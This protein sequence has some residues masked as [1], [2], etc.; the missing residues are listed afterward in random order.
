VSVGGCTTAVGRVGDAASPSAGGGHAA[1]GASAWAQGERIVFRNTE[2]GDEYGLVASVPLGAPGGPRTLGPV[3]CDRV[4]ATAVAFSCLTAQRGVSTSYL[5]T[6][7]SNDGREMTHWPLAGVPSRTRFS[8]DGTL[9][10]TTSFVTGSAYA[11]VGFSTSTSIR[12]VQGTDLAGKLADW[13]LVLDGK[14]AEPADRNYW[15]ITFIDDTTFYATVGLTAAGRTY[16][17]RG[18]LTART[19]TSVASGVECPSLSPDGRRLAFKKVTDGFGPTV[20]WTPAVLELASGRVTVL[21][22]ETHKLDDQIAWLDDR[23]LLYGL[24]GSAPGDS[25]VWALAADG[26][27]APRLFVRHAWSP[28]VVRP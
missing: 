14:R 7:Y 4:A 25:D 8:P 20:H 3:A 5:A 16:L 10:A 19:M 27:S 17:V 12:T 1:S 24:P 9:V 22:A 28:T 6:V 21:S 26:A 15:G 11:S 23:T 2:V 13:T 18:D